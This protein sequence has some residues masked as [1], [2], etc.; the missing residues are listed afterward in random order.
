MRTYQVQSRS[1][2]LVKIIQ[3]GNPDMA[4][5]KWLQELCPITRSAADIAAH[6]PT[7][8]VHDDGIHISVD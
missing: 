3:A 4:V 5:V 1:G 2:M 7:Y 8:Q 6:M